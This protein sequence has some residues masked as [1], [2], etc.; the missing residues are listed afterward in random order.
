[1]QM[2]PTKCNVVWLACRARDGIKI[3][4]I[5]LVRYQ[6]WWNVGVLMNYWMG[7]EATMA[8]GGRIGWRGKTEIKLADL[9]FSFSTDNKF[10]SLGC[11]DLPVLRACKK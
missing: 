3:N 10:V 9:A 2:S 6:R 8:P 11:A 4:L 7:E 1:M 5:T